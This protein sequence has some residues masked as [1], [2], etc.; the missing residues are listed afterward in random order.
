[1]Q[2]FQILVC[3]GPSCGITHESERLVAL[4]KERI[5]A[6]PDLKSRVYC[7]IYDCFGRCS[8]GPNMFVR[9]LAPEERGEVEP[10]DVSGRGFYPGVTEE[11][12]VTIL[13]R[14]AGEGS[15]VEEW[16]EEY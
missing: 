3:E 7:A 9:P 13:E 15:P 5:A 10:R 14:H 8:E 12:A 6:N 1:M 11:Q 4:L 16:V 2:R